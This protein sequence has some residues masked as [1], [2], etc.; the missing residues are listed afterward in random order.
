MGDGRRGGLGH[1]IDDSASPVRTRPESRRRPLD[2]LLGGHR[3]ADT[4]WDLLLQWPGGS[5][6][7]RPRCR[8]DVEG[9]RSRSS[10]FWDLFRKSDLRTC[11][12]PEHLQVA[13]RPSRHQP[14]GEGSDHWQ[15]GDHRSQ[16]RVRCASAAGGGI[17]QPLR[18]CAG[19]PRVL[20]R[21]RRRGTRARGR[22]CLQCAVP[23]RGGSWSSRCRV[24]LR[25]LRGSHRATTGWWRSGPSRARC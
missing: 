25:S 17:R 6:D 16:P 19:L 15:G 22:I 3:G 12:G 11:L 9:S 13:L 2:L 23:P 5:R 4:R 1:Q 21:R 8:V 14:T 24:S 20:E 7:R 10:G 18:T